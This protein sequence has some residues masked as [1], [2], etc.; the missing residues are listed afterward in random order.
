MEPLCCFSVQ[1]EAK[2]STST[3]Q[4]FRF[5][6][7]LFNQ[8]IEL[9]TQV[10]DADTQSFRNDVAVSDSLPHGTDDPN[11]EC[12]AVQDDGTVDRIGLVFDSEHVGHTPIKYSD[13]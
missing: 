6:D 2:G 7:A 10:I 11:S 9:S 5:D 8:S 4:G 12:V 3:G 13:V 1:G